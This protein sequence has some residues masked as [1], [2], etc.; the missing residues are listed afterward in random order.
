MDLDNG[1]GKFIGQALLICYNLPMKRQCLTNRTLGGGDWTP[2]FI[3][4]IDQQKCSHCCTCIK[5]CP[6]GV[7]K[8]TVKGTVEAINK[9]NCYGCTVCERMCPDAAITCLERLPLTS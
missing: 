8:R 5:V 2:R 7:F 9:N 4:D 1:A 6:A 3:R